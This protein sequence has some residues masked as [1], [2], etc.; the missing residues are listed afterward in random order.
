MLDKTDQQLIAEHL[1]G[2]TQAFNLLAERY[3]TPLYGFL[4]RYVNNS[5]DAEDLAQE[6]FVKALRHIARYDQDKKF[7]TWLFAIAKNTALDFLKKKKTL[8]F[9]DLVTPEGD[10]PTIDN[11]ADPAPLPDDLFDQA[12]L[13]ETLKVALSNLPASYQQ[14]LEL[15]YREDLNLREIAEILGTSADTIKSRHRRALIMLRPLL[16][17]N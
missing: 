15:Y 10:N 4:Y 11:L 13:A 6:V 12:N 5:A 8:A 1:A 7:K 16:D 2:D 14:V 17:K 9:S 3:L